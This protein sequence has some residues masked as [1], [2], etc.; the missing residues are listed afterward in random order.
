MATQNTKQHR[1]LQ[2]IKALNSIPKV[3]V[4][5]EE[6]NDEISNIWVSHQQQYVPNFRLQWCPGKEHFRA[7]IFVAHTQYD[8]QNAGYCICVLGSSLAA[9]GFVTLYNF[10]HSHR[11]NNKEVEA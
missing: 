6:K 10:I 5:V 8:K 1:I 3:T 4:T 9:A 2:V 11:A 7:Y